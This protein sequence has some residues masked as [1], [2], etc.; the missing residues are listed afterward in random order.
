MSPVGELDEV[1]LEAGEEL[2][3]NKNHQMGWRG[4]RS[5]EV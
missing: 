2:K 3:L 4:W 1:K 5:L